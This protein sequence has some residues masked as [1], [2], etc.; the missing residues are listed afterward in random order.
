[1]LNTMIHL[2]TSQ[3]NKVAAS[4]R[5]LEP[6]PPAALSS[7]AASVTGLPPDEHAATAQCQPNEP[8]LLITDAHSITLPAL[9]PVLF[10]NAEGQ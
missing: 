8:E 4:G 10:F 3:L 5:V 2:E 9:V 7:A 6:A 1:M